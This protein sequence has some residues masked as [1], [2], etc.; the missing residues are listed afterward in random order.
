MYR[1]SQLVSGM[2]NVL[3]L[4]LLSL[5]MLSHGIA[6]R[7]SQELSGEV[8]F[9]TSRNIYVKFARTDEIQPGDTLR[10]ATN[11]SPCLKVEN[12]SSTSLVCVVIN[13]CQIEKGDLVTY[14]IKERPASVIPVEEAAVETEKPDP[15]EESGEEDEPEI[16]QKIRGRISVAENS[17]IGDM[18]DDRHR[19]MARFTLNADNIAGSG[20]SVES[21]MNYRRIFTGKDTTFSL[22]TTFF[23]VYNLAL[24]YDFPDLTIAVGRRIN[25]RISSI[26]AIDG[27]Q[28]EKRWSNLYLGFIAGSRPDLFSFGYNSSLMEFGGYA[29]L[30]TNTDGFR[31]MTTV[32]LIEQYNN[33]NTDRRY[34]Y[35]QH[36]STVAQKLNL[37]SSVELDLY[38][39]VDSLPVTNLRLTNL[40]V[41]AVYRIN[42]AIS[43]MASYDSRKRIV[44]YETFQTEIERLLDDDIARQGI[45]LRLNIRPAKYVSVGIS[46]SRRFQSDLQNQSENLNGYV[47]L[48]KIPGVGGRLSVSYNHNS[49]QYLTSTALSVRHSRSFFDNKLSAD[50]YYRMGGY[51]YLNS[52]TPFLQHYVGTD[53]S[54]NISRKI[55]ISAAVERA[56]FNGEKNYRLQ[57]KLVNRFYSKK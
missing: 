3:L 42:R 29:G 19:L 39:L 28:F 15:R 44:Y 56:T 26:G 18:R 16:K 51:T 37:F 49:S 23:R 21:Y 7:S 30:Q 9:L 36:S 14:Q 32:G 55:L 45:R 57:F 25:P 5:A 53:L 50:F 38:G 1:L 33:T 31:S 24:R 27:I 6:Q 11:H 48:S 41:S 8:T 12:K 46:A 17:N 54:Y 4:V 22:P 10:L 40:Y 35:F 13:G 34:A 20:F 43:L 2:K 47:S 52:E